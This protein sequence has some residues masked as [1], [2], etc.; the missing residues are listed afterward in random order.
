VPPESPQQADL[1][2]L[3]VARERLG[4]F[5]QRA[6]GVDHQAAQARVERPREVLRETREPFAIDAGA[7][8]QQRKQATA[9]LRALVFL[10]PVSQL[11]AH[12]G[13]VALTR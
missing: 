4:L 6:R 12:G 8:G 9:R 7:H 10:H 11:G 13:A 2:G 5:D 3:G 1:I